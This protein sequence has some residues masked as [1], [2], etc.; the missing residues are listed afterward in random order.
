[1]SCTKK[2]VM[3][4]YYCLV[5]LIVISFSCVR[6]VKKRNLTA[7][8]F[9]FIDRDEINREVMEKASTY[10][11]SV[12]YIPLETNNEN[13]IG[14][15]TKMILS[16]N[17]IHIY[18]SQTNNVYQFDYKGKFVRKI[19]AT[20][21]GPNEYVRISTFSVNPKTGDIAI[22]CE[23]K[24]SIIEFTSEGLPISERKLGFV[25][26]DFIH[27]KDG[28]M[29]YGGRFPNQNIFKDI[30]PEQ[31]RLVNIDADNEIVEKYLP[32]T[33][34]EELL[35]TAITS[36]RNC[37]YYT[38]D[39]ELRLFEKSNGLIYDVN[40]NMKSIYVVDFYKYTIPVAFFYD[41]DIGE[42]D[43][44]RIEKSDCCYLSSFFETDNYIYLSYVV[45]SYNK[46]I[47]QC[48]YLKGSAEAVNIGPVWVNDIENIAMPT[49]IA[50]FNNTLIGYYEAYELKT[51]ID[52]NTKELTP[53]ITE[54]GK[55][56]KESDNPIISI[57]K[58]RD[59][60]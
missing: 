56:V 30:F 23:I 34:K 16:S 47:S 40:N 22:Y 7:D 13:I 46:M 12:Q 3:R 14:N 11:E 6:D 45:N 33:Y 37:L 55:I 20:G 15:V 24:Q 8:T 44:Q 31:Y 28:Y 17:Y 35:R 1:M 21:N 60:S 50:S 48:I 52:S 43:I 58:L 9:I 54:L 42:K 25:C 5:L 49:I 2:L 4:K 32:T 38:H 41:P 39:N 36:E 59:I 29:F 57:I 51:M 27:Y 19:G 53:K 18:D 26:S 10:I